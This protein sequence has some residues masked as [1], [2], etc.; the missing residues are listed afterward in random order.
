[1]KLTKEIYIH[2]EI[3]FDSTERE[4]LT[5]AYKIVDAVRTENIHSTGAEDDYLREKCNDILNGLSE[6]LDHYTNEYFDK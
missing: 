4:V 6:L 5:A 3:I 2:N 1:M